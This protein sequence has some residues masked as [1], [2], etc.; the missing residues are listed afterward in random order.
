MRDNVIKKDGHEKKTWRKRKMTKDELI[1]AF[2]I[3]GC[4]V[5]LAFIYVLVAVGIIMIFGG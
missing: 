5:A 2:E 3:I 1:F 4:I